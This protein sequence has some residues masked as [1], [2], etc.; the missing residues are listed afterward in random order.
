MLTRAQG[1]RTRTRTW[2]WSLRSPLRQ[3]PWTRTNI[4]HDNNN[5]S[6]RQQTERKKSDRNNAKMLLL[7]PL[8]VTVLKFTSTEVC[9]R[10][11]YRW[12]FRATSTPVDYDAR[13]VRKAFC[14][15][16]PTPWPARH[17]PSNAPSP[18]VHLQPGSRWR[19]L[20]VCRSPPLLRRR[21]PPVL[22]SYCRLTAPACKIIE[23]SLTV[24]DGRAIYRSQ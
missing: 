21:T 2:N 15:S 1:S 16:K 11:L 6:N 19:P 8:L 23:L 3:E 14:A 12:T 17:R 24:T 4:P 20:E 13:W 10:A 22:R 7:F 5:N 18:T 9:A